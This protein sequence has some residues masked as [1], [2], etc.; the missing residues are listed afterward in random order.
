MLWFD[1]VEEALVNILFFVIY[2]FILFFLMNMMQN[3]FFQVEQLKEKI[4]LY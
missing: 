4:L 2:M 3:S 1:S